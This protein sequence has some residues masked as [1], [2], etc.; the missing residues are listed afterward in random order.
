[1]MP[2]APEFESESKSSAVSVRSPD[3]IRVDGV[4]REVSVPAL[5]PPVRRGSLADIPFDNAREAPADPVLGIKQ[6]DGTWRDMT[7]AGF[8]ADV[9]AVA[10]GLVAEG[11]RPGDRIAI[12]SRTTYEW[13]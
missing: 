1:M 10:K 4:V 5:V 7:A 2:P 13:T 8:A 12:M 11:L 9:L 6:G 3:K